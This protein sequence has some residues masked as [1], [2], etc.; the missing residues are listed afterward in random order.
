MARTKARLGALAGTLAL[1]A[2][3]TLTNAGPASAAPTFTFSYQSFSNGDYTIN[4]YNN[5][6]LAGSADWYADPHGVTG[7][8]TGDTVG[9]W[10]GL[11]DGYGIAAHL[12]GSYRIATTAGHN[13]PYTD[14]VS[15]DIPEDTPLTLRAYVVKDGDVAYSLGKT[16]YS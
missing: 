3:M 2:G 16:V 13:S 15:G 12:N 7:P 6:V 9:A 8:G 14:Y 5:G 1:A 11:A 10:D 4:V